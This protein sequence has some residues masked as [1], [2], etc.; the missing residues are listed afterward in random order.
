[1]LLLLDCF[2]LLAAEAEH[3]LAIEKTRFRW[4]ELGFKLE[5]SG[6]AGQ[7][8]PPIPISIEI[9]VLGGMGIYGDIWGRSHQAQ[10]HHF[11]SQE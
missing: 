5:G 7:S 9:V 10:L 4:A 2:D 6:F 1:M 11:A 8:H 3:L